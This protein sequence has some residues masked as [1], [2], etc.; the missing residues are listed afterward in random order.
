[1]WIVSITDK[2]DDR[3]TSNID[4][5]K[6]VVTIT[7]KTLGIII[8]SKIRSFS[9]PKLIFITYHFEDFL[10][11]LMTYTTKHERRKIPN[12]N[13]NDNSQKKEDCEVQLK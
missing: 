13:Y 9:N 5:K 8:I 6:A 1:M 11:R 2:N 12:S 10:N 7:V 3:E 4:P